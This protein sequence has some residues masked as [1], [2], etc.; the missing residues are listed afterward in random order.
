MTTALFLVDLDVRQRSLS[1]LLLAADGRG[2]TVM[3]VTTVPGPIAMLWLD[4][5]AARVTHVTAALRRLVGVCGVVVADEAA[6]TVT[7]RHRVHVS[8]MVD[9]TV[10][11]EIDGASRL[12][13][14]DG[15]TLLSATHEAVAHC[16]GRASP[17]EDGWFTVHP[18]TGHPVAV[19][20][21]SAC[22]TY[23]AGPT[24]EAAALAAVLVS[25]PVEAV[26][27]C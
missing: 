2:A 22:A 9:V 21:G 3:G 20:R 5:P 11:L 7:P 6:Q 4:L 15:L 25:C 17:A 14:G 13:A 27:K 18:V 10:E 8:D 1:R 12:G 16:V 23:A 24:P 19:V 26:H